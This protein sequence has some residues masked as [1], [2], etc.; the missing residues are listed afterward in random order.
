MTDF[1]IDDFQTFDIQKRRQELANPPV[2]QAV[3]DARAKTAQMAQN[4]NRL[5]Q[6]VALATGRRAGAPMEIPTYSDAPTTAQTKV[7]DEEAARE[8]MRSLEKMQEQL[9]RPIKQSEIPAIASAY[10]LGTK[11]L[12]IVDKYFK[13]IGRTE[14][15]ERAARA[16]QRAIESA[17]RAVSAEERAVRGEERAEITFTQEQEQAASADRVNASVFGVMSNHRAD[18][19]GSSPETV[20]NRIEEAVADIYADESLSEQEKL[21]AAAKVYERAGKVA[22]L[23]KTQRQELNTAQDR[24]VAA[25]SRALESGRTIIRNQLVEEA[26][27]RLNNGEDF[28]S[29]KEDIMLKANR[30]IMDKDIIASVRS[31]LDFLKKDKA[32]A[33]FQYVSQMEK[34]LVRMFDPN[35]PTQDARGDWKENARNVASMIAVE[36]RTRG[37]ENP[38]FYSYTKK[39]RRGIVIES[40]L[41]AYLRANP[42]AFDINVIKGQFG[43]WV[44][45]FEEGSPPN[46]IQIDGVITELA[47]QIGM[48]FEVAEYILF[49]KRFVIGAKK[50][51]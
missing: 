47:R 34:N 37:N 28:Q 31:G 43:N 50:E 12:A 13:Y 4:Y 24:E 27:E 3:L 51:K 6:F 44:D 42:G 7:A 30:D 45:G 38:V 46:K 5:N 22:N 10:G 35:D 8:F 9:G 33:P 29:V 25:R 21:D 16:E 1:N 17:E 2:S 41:D 40:I 49:P 11:G 39:Q 48:P 32:P 23:N 18:I 36:E 15:Q 26:I 19:V 20:V 14:E